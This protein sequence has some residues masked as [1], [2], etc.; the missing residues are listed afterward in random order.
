MCA[1]APG[2]RA[3]A[4]GVQRL[5]TYGLAIEPGPRTE[6]WMVKMWSAPVVR[7][8]EDAVE[9]EER[10]PESYVPGYEKLWGDEIACG[11]FEK[12]WV[13]EF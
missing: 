13:P 9:A 8:F 4:D 2:V 7:L 3:R 1:A 12:G 6:A 10:L 11:R 5:R